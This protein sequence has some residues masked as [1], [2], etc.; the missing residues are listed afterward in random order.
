MAHSNTSEPHNY[1]ASK[2]P[3]IN[4]LI[5]S[6]SETS[7]AFTKFDKEDNIIPSQNKTTSFLST[8][9]TNIEHSI[10]N[11]NKETGNYYNHLSDHASIKS[12]EYNLSEAYTNIID[13][14]PNS[15]TP[16]HTGQAGPTHE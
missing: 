4:S 5:S 2:S 10:I 6:L 12:K 11:P 13:A 16:R 15:D 1:H 7:K 9:L 8:T 14:R 3:D